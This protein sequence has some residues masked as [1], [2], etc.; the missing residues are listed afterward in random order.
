MKLLQR[1]FFDEVNL[2]LFFNNLEKDSFIKKQ[3]LHEALRLS[4][5]PLLMRSL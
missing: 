4:K 1:L 3:S 5:S 2:F